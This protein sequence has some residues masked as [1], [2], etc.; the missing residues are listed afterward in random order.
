MPRPSENLRA[1]ASASAAAAPASID[2]YVAAFPP[3]VQAILQRI[4]TT[5]RDAA[6]DAREV[7]S[8]QMPAFKQH[9][10]LVYFA[11]FKHHIGLYPP[12]SGDASLEKDLA[13]YTGPKG[14]LRFPLDQPMRYD[15]IERVTMLR[16]D[17]DAAKAALKGA[18]KPR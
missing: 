9:G 10:V 13:P 18:R 8:Y 16:V 15:L 2:E 17:Q 3:D 4:R 7:I 12:V 1:D 5:I 11:A 14:N 6:P